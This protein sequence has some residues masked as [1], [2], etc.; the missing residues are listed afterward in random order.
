MV[1]KVIVKA[2]AISLLSIMGFSQCMDSASGLT[3]KNNKAEI[4][5]IYLLTKECNS[6]VNEYQ[7]IL[8]DNDSKKQS[9][10]DEH[11]LGLTIAIQ[12]SAELKKTAAELQKAQKKINDLDKRNRELVAKSTGHP[13]VVDG[14]YTHRLEQEQ[15]K[16]A[17]LTEQ[18]KSKEVEKE[19]YVILSEALNTQVEELKKLLV[20]NNNDYLKVVSTEQKA[21][22]SLHDAEK[23]NAALDTDIRAVLDL[24]K[25]KSLTREDINSA[26][27]ALQVIHFIFNQHA[28]TPIGCLLAELCDSELTDEQKKEK[29]CSLLVVNNELNSNYWS[30]KKRIALIVPLSFVLYA[31]LWAYYQGYFQKA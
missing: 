26:A 12:Q 25:D 8:V 31:V 27:K 15:K 13:V 3:G 6:V 5:S 16:S 19:K 22:E 10:I 1:N 2:V 7:L 4:V 28:G 24:E 20:A 23:L 30:P 17:R 21:Q 9:L 14:T 18:L 29:I 11:H